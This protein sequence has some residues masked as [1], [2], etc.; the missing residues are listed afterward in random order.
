MNGTQTIQM[1]LEQYVGTRIRE[2]RRLLKL[3]QSELASLMGVSYQQL[4]KYE[5]GVNALTLN[6]LIQMAQVMNAPPSYFYD[7]A[8]VTSDVATISEGETIVTERTRPLQILLVEDNSGDEILFRNAVEQCGAFSEIQVLQNPD[9]VIDF[10]QNH[11]SK[12]HARP[13]LIVLDI[14]LPRMDG[15]TLLREIKSCE[16]IADI[17]VIILTNSVRTKE[18]KESY[19][20]NASGFI[21]KSLKYEEFCDNVAAAM[22]YW[23]RTVILPV[24]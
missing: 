22:N 18:M 6:R 9:M 8:P 2:R 17:P 21:Q 24:M 15:L 14:N 20:L 23:T 16:T 7:G 12:G 13:H 4:Q 11:E 5:N 1:T 19:R 10:I 3:S